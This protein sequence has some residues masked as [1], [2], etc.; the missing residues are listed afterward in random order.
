MQ[1]FGLANKGGWSGVTLFFVLSGFLITGILWDS[2]S[3]EH[4]W[5]KFFA[6][7]TLRIFPLYFLTLLLVLLASI[8][9]GTA[10]SVLSGLWIPALFLENMPYLSRV[11]ET[12]PSPLPIF[13]LWSIAV[14]EQFYL[15]WPFVLYWC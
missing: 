15:V 2:Y 8:A 5:R 11:S 12:L 1:L 6:R 14:E 13:H 7:R 4:W 10:G 3:D 9:G